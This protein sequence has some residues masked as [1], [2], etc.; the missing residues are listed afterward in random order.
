MVEGLFEDVPS[1]TWKSFG[2]FDCRDDLP[3]AQPVQSGHEAGGRV[4][5]GAVVSGIDGV[6]LNGL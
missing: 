4:R 6:R 1:C 3:A 2:P 5:Y